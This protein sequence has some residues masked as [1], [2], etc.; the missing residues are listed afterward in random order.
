[1]KKR[2]QLPFRGA[3]NNSAFYDAG[4]PFAPQQNLRNVI[5]FDQTKD[6][7]RIGTRPGL[8][9]Y[10]SGTFGNGSR[11]QG[12]GVVSR[13]RTASGFVLGERTDLPN[14]NGSARTQGAVTGNF[15]RR[16]NNWGLS[17]YAYENATASGPYSDTGVNTSPNKG[18]NAIARSPDGTK[19]VTGRSY[20]NGTG[21]NVARVTC[22]DAATNTVIWSKR[23]DDPGINRFV[24]SIVVHSDWVFVFTNHFIRIFRLSDGA[25]APAGPSVWN[26]N[27]WSSEA[28]GGCLLSGGNTM[29]ALFRGSNKVA[30]LPSG[31]TVS[32]GLT[33]RHFRSG[34]M[35]LTINTAA[36]L[37]A[38]TKDRVLEQATFGA[39]ITN[40]NT[41]YEANH[42]YLRF[43]EVLPWA[44]RGLEPLGIALL[45]SNGFVVIHANQAWGPRATAG[46]GYAPPDGTAG[47]RTISAFTST[48][49]LDWWVDTDS[50]IDTADGSGFYNDIANPTL[51]TVDADSD[52][53]VYASGRRTKNVPDADGTSVW[54][55]NRY[56]DYLWDQDLGQTGSNAV[57]AIRVLPGSKNIVAGGDRNN[58]W[59]SAT[60]QAH[61]WELNKLDGS[62]IRSADLGA[63]ASV[64]GIETMADDTVAHVT[65]FI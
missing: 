48:G 1:M 11:I 26:F 63:S 15:W 44:P 17:G 64:L 39:G 36:Q 3:S 43:S 57:R 29:Y 65:D 32:A 35:K 46:T 54:A 23:M 41:Y 12:G 14:T 27:G 25:N 24:N 45:P 58:A 60:G 19:I 59:P 18:I 10:F 42:R 52:G 53:N 34:V 56:G 47:Y 50:R 16:A 5:R 13:G 31:V 40:A 28:I 62:I 37:A 33:A 21:S 8:S 49:A 61:L 7:P 20:D 4:S 2:A 55:F 30:T 6:R 9:E 38:G 51:L 22:W